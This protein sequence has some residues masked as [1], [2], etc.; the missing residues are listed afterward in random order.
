VISYIPASTT[1]FA[2]PIKIRKQRKTESLM[3]ARND[4]IEN[5]AGS[6]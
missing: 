2:L 5:V 4:I 6:V 1:C 3:N